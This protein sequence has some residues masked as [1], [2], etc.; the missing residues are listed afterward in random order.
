MMLHGGAVLLWVAFCVFAILV[1]VINVSFISRGTDEDVLVIVI[2][3]LF[4]A[5]A[6]PVGVAE[7]VAGARIKKL[8]SRKL[9]LGALFASV[10]SFFCGNVFCVPFSVA[11]LAFGIITL[12][13]KRVTEAFNRVEAGEPPE[14]FALE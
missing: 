9:A 5:G 6:F 11:L 14:T 2:Y 8:K 12:L 1:G 10:F 4:A 7:I 3:S 13:D